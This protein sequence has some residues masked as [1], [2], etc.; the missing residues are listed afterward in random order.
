MID[1]GSTDDEDDD[2]RQRWHPLD[3]LPPALWWGGSVLAARWLAD[4]QWHSGSR[5]YH[6]GCVAAFVW[7]LVL[8]G[9][10][11]WVTLTFQGG[12]LRKAKYVMRGVFFMTSLL[13]VIIALFW[14]TGKG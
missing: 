2:G 14:V 1:D 7:W 9:I 3:W 10:L 4:T 6:A 13:S 5:T 12:D 8:P 11:G